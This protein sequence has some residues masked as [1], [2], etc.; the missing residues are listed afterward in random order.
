VRTVPP[1]KPK[2]HRGVP[3]RLNPA[4]ADYLPDEFTL[5]WEDPPVNDYRVVEPHHFDRLLGEIL[6]WREDA[7]LPD[8]AKGKEWRNVANPDRIRCRRRHWSGPRSPADYECEYRH[9]PGDSD[10]DR[11]TDV[12]ITLGE[13][14]FVEA[15]EAG[16]PDH[17]LPRYGWRWG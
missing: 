7:P 13:M 11:T 12:T 4:L 16:Y 15:G 10:R 3:D 1:K 9:R 2:N 6:V 17:W 5:Q 14:V 8:W